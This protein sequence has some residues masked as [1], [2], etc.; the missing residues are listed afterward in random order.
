MQIIE[1]DRTVTLAEQLADT[2]DPVIL[3]NTFTVDPEDVE[4]FL[5]TWGDDSRHRNPRRAAPTRTTAP[6]SAGLSG[7]CAPEHLWAI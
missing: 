6:C 4:Q 1:M 5:T 3:I 2:G 7:S